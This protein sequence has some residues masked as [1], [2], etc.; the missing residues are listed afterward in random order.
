MKTT[1]VV[2]T[3]GALIL[4]LIGLAIL[5][6]QGQPAGDGPVLGNED[7]SDRAK[8]IRAA[9]PIGPEPDQLDLVFAA[10]AALANGNVPAVIINVGP[11]HPAGAQVVVRCRSDSRI[12]SYTVDSAGNLMLPASEGCEQ[13]NEVTRR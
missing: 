9:V 1:S 5:F 3:V 8:A 4:V 6:T 2:A 7:S 12:V 11:A 10:E 13:D